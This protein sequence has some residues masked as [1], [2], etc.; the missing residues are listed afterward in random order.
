MLSDAILNKL[1]PSKNHL[2][3]KIPEISSVDNLFHS[4]TQLLWNFSMI[5]RCFVQISH[6][7]D[8]LKGCYERSGFCEIWV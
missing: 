4:G 8:N 5:P 1:Y 6:R 3:R 7:L 2:K